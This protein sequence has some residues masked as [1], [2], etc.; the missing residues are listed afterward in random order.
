MIRY[1]SECMAFF[2]KKKGAI[3]AFGEKLWDSSIKW[4]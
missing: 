1:L 4:L 3:I 2:I